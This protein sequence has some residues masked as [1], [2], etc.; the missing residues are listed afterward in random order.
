MEVTLEQVE[1]ALAH[2]PVYIKSYSEDEKYDRE[3]TNQDIIGY[4]TG[5]Q[6]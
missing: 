4:W 1:K 5:S 2:L 3:G 6:I